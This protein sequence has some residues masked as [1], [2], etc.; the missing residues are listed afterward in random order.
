MFDGNKKSGLGGF[1]K[2]N[3][4]FVVKDDAFADSVR[5]YPSP[6]TISRNFSETPFDENRFQPTPWIVRTLPLLTVFSRS[7]HPERLPSRKRG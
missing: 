7:L 5:S 4:D 2:A 6:H 3:N 1:G